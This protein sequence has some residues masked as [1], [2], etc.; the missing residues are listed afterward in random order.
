MIWLFGYL[1]IC[2]LISDFIAGIFHWVED[3]YDFSNLPLVGGFID[4]QILKPNANHHLHPQ[5][6]TKNGFWYRNYT[7]FV[8]SFIVGLLV[9]LYNPYLS[10]PIFMSAF[11]NQVHYLSHRQG[12][13]SEFTATLQEI[14]IFQSP[15]QHSLHHTNPY[16]SYY[17]PMTDFINPILQ[18]INFWEK[19]E[20]FVS[21]VFRVRPKSLQNYK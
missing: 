19:L 3:R 11:G 10:T 5:D 12:K 15:K 9:F 17:C 14:G 1:L 20:N 7:N 4:D 16:D 13:V 18:R 2:W 21:L 8:P 6:F